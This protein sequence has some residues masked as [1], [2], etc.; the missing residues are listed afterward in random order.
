MII[1][2][3]HI[4]QRFIGGAVAGYSKGD[5]Y[6]NGDIWTL[7]PR[8]R[9]NKPMEMLF[10]WGCF[11]ISGGYTYHYKRNWLLKNFKFILIP[12]LLWAIIGLIFN[13]VKDVVKADY[14]TI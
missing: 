10:L 3:P 12:Y 14:I 4:N 7:L 13:I 9:L 8:F 11:F 2:A 1:T 6:A 5:L